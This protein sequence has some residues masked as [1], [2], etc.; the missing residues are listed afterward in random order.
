MGIQQSLFHPLHSTRER[1]VSPLRDALVARALPLRRLRDQHRLRQHRLRLRGPGRGRRRRP[2]GGGGGA[3]GPQE[4]EVA[5]GRSGEQADAA[6]LGNQSGEILR[7]K[8]T[9]IF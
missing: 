9:N 5:V 6:E 7:E 1:P 3:G 4:G 8:E 2:A